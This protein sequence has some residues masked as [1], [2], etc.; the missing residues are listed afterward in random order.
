MA[1]SRLSP[2]NISAI[3]HSS[4]RERL[5]AHGRKIAVASAR[6][7]AGD[8]AFKNCSRSSNDKEAV[9]TYESSREFYEARREPE[10]GLMQEIVGTVIFTVGAVG[11]ILFVLTVFIL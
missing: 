10:I 9:M 11:L 6:T 8:V 1:L 5:P 7:P 4:R 2:V 3:P